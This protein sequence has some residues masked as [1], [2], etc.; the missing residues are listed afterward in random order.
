MLIYEIN[1]TARK[2]SKIMKDNERLQ[3]LIKK[4]KSKA[5]TEF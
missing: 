5:S 2:M 4:K 3:E 1:F